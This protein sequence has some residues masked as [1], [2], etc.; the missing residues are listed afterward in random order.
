[1]SIVS[2][3]FQKNDAFK[4]VAFLLYIWEGLGSIAD[5]ETDYP[6]LSVCGFLHPSWPLFANHGLAEYR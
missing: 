4:W 6:D 2:P 1:M 5:P 3:Y